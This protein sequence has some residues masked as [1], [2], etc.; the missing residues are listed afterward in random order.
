MEKKIIDLDKEYHCSTD[1]YGKLSIETENHIIEVKGIQLLD[2]IG[3]SCKKLIRG[4]KPKEVS[5]IPPTGQS[6]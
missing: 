4:K 6:L 1:N 3:A 5:Q 2:I